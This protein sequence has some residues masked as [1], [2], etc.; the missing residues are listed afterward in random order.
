MAWINYYPMPNQKPKEGV[1]MSYVK[2]AIDRVR[3][4]YEVARTNQC[5]ATVAHGDLGIVLGELEE[6][7]VTKTRGE[8]MQDKEII[9]N[10]RKQLASAKQ[11]YEELVNLEFYGLVKSAFDDTYSNHVAATA[12]RDVPYS[13]PWSPRELTLRPREAMRFCDEFRR[14]HHTYDVPDDLI[15]KALLEPPE[16]AG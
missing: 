4:R 2:D 5:G 7:R 15:L 16:E 12:E 11:K 1:A 14:K 8:T 10:L 3:A 13:S 6:L 9:E